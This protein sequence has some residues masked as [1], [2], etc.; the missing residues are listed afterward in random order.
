M[1][2]GI[3][4][5]SLKKRI[6]ARTSFKRVLRHSVGLK[7][8]RGMGLITN[9]KRAIYNKVYNKTT[10]SADRLLSNAKNPKR[11]ITTQS[12]S[13]IWNTGNFKTREELISK[14]KES[15]VVTNGKAVCERCEADYWAIAYVKLFFIKGD[16]VFCQN[17]GR[18][19]LSIS[20][21]NKIRENQ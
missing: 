16:A 5:P 18:P 14:A 2:F 8:P 6:S 11:T 1:K 9:P 19:G 17:C 3:R 21:F 15:G 12:Q 7:A 4:T 10:L 20:A 13:E